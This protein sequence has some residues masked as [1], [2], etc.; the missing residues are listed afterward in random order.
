MQDKSRQKKKEVTAQVE[1]KLSTDGEVG[2]G[3]VESG[4]GNQRLVQKAPVLNKKRGEGHP[5][6]KLTEQDVR[7]IRSLGE[8]GLTHRAIAAKFEVSKRAVEAVL[9]GQSWRHV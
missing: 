2:E 4:E 8:H 6:A 3:Q 7:L 9:T 1:P 5:K